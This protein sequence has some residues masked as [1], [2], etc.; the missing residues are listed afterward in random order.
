[1]PSPS[2]KPLG[3][4]A[5]LALVF[6]SIGGAPAASAQDDAGPDVEEPREAESARDRP[7]ARGAEDA[8]EAE[9]EPPGTDAAETGD[10]READGAAP[11]SAQA[12]AAAGSERAPGSDVAT[13]DERP[14]EPRAG[15][16]AAGDGGGEG[17]DGPAS[18]LAPVTADPEEDPPAGWGVLFQAGQGVTVA[19]DDE[20]FRLNISVRGQFRGVVRVPSDA[21][22][23][24]DFLI[25][26]ARVD[27]SGHFFGE[28]NRFELE[29]A[30]SPDDLGWSPEAGVMRSPLL[31]YILIFD[32]LR[33]LTLVV[34][35]RK[36]PYAR[37]RLITSGALA[38]VER[39]IVDSALQ[40]D[41]DTGVW[42]RSDDFLGAGFFRYFLGVS[43]GEGRDGLVGED[44]DLAYSARVEFLPLGI[45]DSY[46]QGDLRRN[47]APRLAIGAS[48]VFID[49]SPWVDGLSG[50][51]PEDGGTT[52]THQ[53]A[54]DAIFL[55]GG[56]TAE[57]DVLM[58]YGDRRPGTAGPIT[59][60]SN[61]AGGMV[62][63]SYLLPDTIVELT[64][65]YG[66]VLGVGDATSLEDRGELGGAISLYFEGHPLKLQLDYFH[67][68]DDF[69]AFDQ[70]EE[71]VRL[72][73]QATL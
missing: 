21:D 29:L 71:R 50:T 32:H 69:D 60:A 58:R 35:Q 9:A 44:A 31:D 55:W 30:F 52:D 43:A 39:S 34:G 59:L 25:R 23:S 68:W 56:F 48:Y 70:G 37:E 45:F 38:M 63:L 19:S 51:L 4:V 18:E 47:P 46:T 57:L 20:Q 61:G 2:P 42:I 65:R 22:A 54:L 73:L 1:M 28:H 72:Q 11:E 33:D 27:L 40:I 53:A 17:E 14:S 41:R 62:Q 6:A 49:D 67:L 10:V 5:A 13:E 36:M 15:A 12:E 26:R 24:V 16:D 8:P 64:A 66:M 3:S 7:R